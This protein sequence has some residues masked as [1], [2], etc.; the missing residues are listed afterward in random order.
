MASRLACVSSC[1]LEEQENAK[2]VFTCICRRQVELSPGV[3]W[4]A[5][6][7]MKVYSDRSAHL[8]GEAAFSSPVIGLRVKRSALAPITKVKSRKNKLKVQCKVINK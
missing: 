3:P 5:A 1:L 7:T 2:A 6:V 4:S 8:R